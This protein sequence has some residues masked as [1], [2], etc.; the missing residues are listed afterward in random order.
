MAGEPQVTEKLLKG[1]KAGDR[2]Y[3]VHLDGYNLVPYL[4]GK[5]EK[6]PRESFIYIDD[7]QQVSGLRYDNWKFVFMEQRVQGT[8][9]IWSEPLVSLRVPKIFNLRTD[10]YERADI[11]SNTYYDWLLDHAFQLVPVQAYVGQFLMSF[12][13]YPQRQKAASFN[14]DKVM[15]QLQENH[16]SK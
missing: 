15:E 6:S 5:A 14:L 10:P 1:F 13:E 8:L 9:R 3:K 2:T 7:D 12:K 16:G 4:T 11:T